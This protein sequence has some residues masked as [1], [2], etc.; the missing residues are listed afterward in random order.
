MKKVFI[1]VFVLVFYGC[2]KSDQSST[3]ASSKTLI[4]DAG[5]DTTICMP[6]GGTGNLF[7]GILNGR[8][9]SDGSGK[10]LSYAW[11]EIGSTPSAVF[12]NASSTEITLYGGLH[13][14]LLKIG[15]DQNRVKYDT[16]VFNVIQRFNTEYDGLTWDSTVG[17]LNTIGVRPKPALIESWPGPYKNIEMDTVYVSNYDGTCR[18]I[19]SWKQIPYVPYDSIQ[20]TDKPLFYSIVFDI[21]NSV[22]LGTGYPEIFAKTN[23][24]ID[25]SQK[26]SIGFKNDNPTGA[27]D[28]DY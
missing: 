26:V 18:D 23:A 27:G 5:S 17:V 25:F 8:N 20:L 9:S 15:D 16:V 22:N 3:Q 14:F 13:Q 11:S 7:K 19:G 6:Y 28:W 24:G 12:S 2:T 1:P 10:I 21:P 4:A